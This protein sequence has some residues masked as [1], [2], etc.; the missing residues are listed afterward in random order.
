MTKKFRIWHASGVGETIEADS[1]KFSKEKDG[2]TIT[3]MSGKKKIKHRGCLALVEVSPEIVFET[4][5]PESENQA[6]L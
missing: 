4:V 6:R 5:K 3:A 2:I 1:V